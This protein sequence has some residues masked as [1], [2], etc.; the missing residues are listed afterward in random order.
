MVP[1]LRLDNPWRTL[2]QLATSDY[3]LV[4]VLLVLASALLLAAWLPQA[5]ASG[6]NA[7]VAW[8]AEV[9]RRFGGAAWFDLLRAPLQSLGA[10][11]VVDAVGFRLL[12]ALLAFCLSVRLVD[13]AEGAWREWRGDG[14]HTEAA[15][16]HAA[17]EQASAAVDA[18]ELASRS[19]RLPWGELGLAAIY[20]GALVTLVGAVVTSLQGWQTGPLPVAPDESIPLRA[21]SDLSLRLKTLDP[22][23]R[24]GVGELV[25][26]GD[27]LVGTGDL[28]VG[29]PLTGAGVGVY[30]VGSGD[31]LR[32]QA[33]MSATQV[34]ELVS[35]PGTARQE[36]VSLIF[37]EDEPHQVVG[38]PEANLV[39]LVS[40]PEADRADARPRVQVFEEGSG[41]FILEQEAPGDT[42]L[43][44]GNVSFALRSIPVARVQVVRDP[45]A[46]WSQLGVLV[47]VVGLLVRGAGLW[48]RPRAVEHLH[49]IQLE[50]QAG[51]LAELETG[52][53]RVDPV[54]GAAR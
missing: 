13:S 29:R 6:V 39:L 22:Q 2:W 37:T 43:T 25:L 47:L 7:D 51:R 24:R 8:Q 48:Q 33:T 46:F 11:R 23:A 9:Q 17:E 27:R 30:L 3:L 28:A 49:G 21:D 44:V 16:A 42:A 10:F 54:N 4:A 53:A 45:G 35:G 20:L 19:R 41:A 50:N 18:T 38:V 34:L 36:D 12:L 40:L 15:Q 14:Q 52:A 5:A 31:G 26:G 1:R 32:V